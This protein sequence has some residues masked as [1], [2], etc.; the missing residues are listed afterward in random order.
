MNPNQIPTPSNQP[1]QSSQETTSLDTFSHQESPIPVTDSLYVS[2]SSTTHVDKV[3]KT[4]MTLQK[5]FFWLGI[6]VV[7]L[8]VVLIVV[9]RFTLPDADIPFPMRNQELQLKESQL[10]NQVIWITEQ[11]SLTHDIKVIVKQWSLQI[12]WDKLLSVNN[13]V[14][15]KGFTLPHKTFITLLNWTGELQ[16]A[17]YF[18]TRSYSL[19]ELDAYMKKII[20]DNY[21]SSSATLPTFSQT[22]LLYTS[23]PLMKYFGVQCLLYPTQT[24]IVCNTLAQSVLPK[25]GIYN[26]TNHYSELIELSDKVQRT[27]HQVTFC[28][29]IK[30]YLFLS[31]DLNDTIKQVMEQCGREYEDMFSEF[32]AFRTIQEQL[33]KQSVQPNVTSSAVLNS[34]KLLSVMQEIYQEITKGNSINDLRISSYLDYVRSLL[35]NTQ[36]IQ[37]F[38]MDVIA[39]YNNTFLSPVLTKNSVVARWDEAAIYRKLLLEVNEINQGSVSKWFTGL[40]LLVS[41]PSL[42]SVSSGALYTGDTT[43]ALNLS[44][45]ERFT[46]SYSFTNFIILNAKENPNQTLSVEW[47]LRFDSDVWLTNNTPLTAV[48][49]YKDQRFYVQSIVMPRQPLLTLSINPKLA[50]KPLSISELYDLIVDTQKWLSWAPVTSSD[51]CSTFKNDKTLTSCTPQQAVFTRNSIKY[52]FTYNSTQW[53]TNY[54]IS[55]KVLEQSVMNTY[56][57][58]ITLTKNPV[59]AIT[60]LLSH[61]V[62]KEN[63]SPITWDVGWVQEV[64]I[65]KHFDEIG[66]TIVKITKNNAYYVIQ[67]TIQSYNF[68][69]VYDASTQSIIGL[70]ITINTTTYPIRNFQFQFLTA[71]V[72]DKTL[73]KNDP[74]TLLLQYDPL[75]IKKLQL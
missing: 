61:K 54:S 66:A 50:I 71:S 49:L 30:Q 27:S 23:Q 36:Y 63:I 53:V 43:I 48:F 57:S 22:Q 59:E 35:K 44:L 58:A 28:N 70:G 56:W 60:I 64:Q 2:W 62:E 42:I 31:N 69:A 52:V 38:Y 15:Y 20:F 5:L 6:H 14:T 17:S 73:F 3:V 39:R 75:T 26:L 67:F 4:Y 68:T 46:Q 10:Q 18:T 40:Q 29:A 37:W 41:N 12:Q 72:A 1:L 34:Y 74:K 16:P 24:N 21:A 51:V 45:S 32:S 11:D 13:L 47:R 55:D 25:L 9:W 65:Q 7:L 33:S 19:D 8:I